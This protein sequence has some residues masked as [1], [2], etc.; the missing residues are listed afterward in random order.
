MAYP[1]V[2][3]DYIDAITYITEFMSFYNNFRYHGE[4]GFVTPEQ[5]R[6]G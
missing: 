1:V 2:F 5:R 6:T 4:I 3:E